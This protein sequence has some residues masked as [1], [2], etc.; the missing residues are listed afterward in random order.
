MVTSSTLVKV[1]L[2]Y[3]GTLT[4]EE[5]QV[6]ELAERSIETLAVEIL[7]VPRNEVREDYW[8]TRELILAE[9][10]RYW[11]EVN[12]GIAAYGDEGAF[13]TNTTTI[14]TML[15]LNPSYEAAVAD[16]F[17]SV[18]YDP[19]VDCTN[20]LFHMH[21]FDL[22]PHFRP[23]AGPVL[24]TFVDDPQVEPVVLSSSKGDKVSKNLA[25]IGFPEVRVLGDTRQYDI[26]PTWTEEFQHPEQ[27]KGQIFRLDEKRTIDLRRPAYYAALRREQQD[28]TR[29]AVVADTFSMPGALPLMMG[30]PFLLLQTLYTPE[31][32]ERYVGA[33]P[34]GQVLT[35]L[36]ELPE[37][38]E[39]LL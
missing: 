25:G 18:E 2:D 16:Y 33:H 13:I 21:T 20:Y 8:R 26:D 29:L 30:I 39:A 31:W 9:P 3:D 34:C 4:A 7:R 24:E 10:H 14:Q 1:I 17:P 28:S 19:I 15:R 6:E 27:G 35:D 36:R 38:V 11:W 23:A 12:G 22:E 37:R 32:C 5:E